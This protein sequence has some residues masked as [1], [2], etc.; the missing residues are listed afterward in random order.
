MLSS[1]VLGQA[2]VVTLGRQS[3]QMVVEVLDGV[4]EGWGSESVL[5][6][7]LQIPSASNYHLTRELSAVLKHIQEGGKDK[8]F[9]SQFI[10]KISRIDYK[11]I[12]PL[13]LVVKEII[14][15]MGH[16]D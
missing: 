6:N 3:D 1:V 15:Y 7:V 11:G 5:Y 16:L 10:N 12:E 13:E 4:F 14:K 2:S 9:L 8:V